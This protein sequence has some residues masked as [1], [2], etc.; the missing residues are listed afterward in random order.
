V[1]S[2]PTILRGSRDMAR[3]LLVIGFDR[4]EPLGGE[5]RHSMMVHQPPGCVHR[6]G[7]GASPGETPPP[8]F[9]DGWAAAGLW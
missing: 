9:C 4:V 8:L 6:V 3:A 2:H 7:G 1:K 5:E